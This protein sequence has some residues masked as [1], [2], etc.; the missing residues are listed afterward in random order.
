MCG[1][2]MCFWFLLVLEVVCL[3][4]HSDGAR[5]TLTSPL[6]LGVVCVEKSFSTWRESPHSECE[7]VSSLRAPKAA[8]ISGQG[9]EILGTCQASLIGRA[10][11]LREKSPQLR[12][13]GFDDEGLDTD[14]TLYPTGTFSSIQSTAR[15]E[16]WSSVKHPD[17]KSEGGVGGR[18]SFRELAAKRRHQRQIGLSGVKARA[19]EED[20]EELPLITETA[21]GKS[22]EDAT[23][24]ELCRRGKAMAKEHKIE[25]AMLAYDSVSA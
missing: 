24:Q 4:T 15:G 25:E 19:E 2:H 8:E 5:E 17:A 12:G 7:R 6:V 23:P 14:D 1:R 20:S 16:G 3:A 9:A 13:G 22:K 11:L 21:H 18:V 10:H